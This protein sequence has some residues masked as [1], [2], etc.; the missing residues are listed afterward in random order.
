MTIPCWRKCLMPN[1]VTKSR[2]NE[3]L[4]RRIFALTTLVLILSMRVYS[5]QNKT[6]DTTDPAQPFLGRWDLTLKTPLRDYPSWL[7]ITQDD[8]QLRARGEPL[9]TCAAPPE[10]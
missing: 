8:G 1:L 3:S 4:W 5:E 6:A 9:G 7:E 2:C 10:N